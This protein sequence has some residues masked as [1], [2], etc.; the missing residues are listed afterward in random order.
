MHNFSHS[1]QQRFSGHPVLVSMHR[2]QAIAQAQAQHQHTKHWTDAATFTA[3]RD[4]TH[5][6]RRRHRQRSGTATG[7]IVR[8]LNGSRGWWWWC[9]VLVMLLS[10][11]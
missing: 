3:V 10:Q 8:V 1:P 4:A 5:R 6:R 9:L 11:H 7:N 2:F